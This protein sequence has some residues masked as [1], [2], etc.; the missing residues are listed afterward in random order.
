[1]K[2]KE[3]I[4][5]ITDLVIMGILECIFVIVCYIPVPGLK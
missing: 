1:M 3:K 5:L 2:R 4:K